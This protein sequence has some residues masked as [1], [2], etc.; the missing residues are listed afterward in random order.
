MNSKKRPRRLTRRDFIRWGSGSAL[1]AL[2][3][4]Q[5]TLKA[6]AAPTSPPRNA[7]TWPQARPGGQGAVT[8]QRLAATDGH[9][10]LPGRRN[11]D[12]KGVYVFGF[13]NASIPASI[14]ETILANKG[15]VKHPS[16]ILDFQQDNDVYLTLTNVGFEFRPDLDDSHTIHWHGFRNPNAIFDGVPEVSISVPVARDFVYYFHPRHPGTYMYHCHF[17]DTEHVQMGMDGIVFVRPTMGRN[18]AYNHPATYFDREY[19][20]LLNEVDTVPHDNLEAVQGFVWSD[21]NPNYF[22]ING[23]AYPD[24]ILRNGEVGEDPT[25][26]ESQPISSLIQINEEETG[27]LRFASL[28]YEQH[29][30][31][32]VGIRMHV[33][34]HDATPLYKANGNGGFV[35]LTYQTSTIY[36][37]A[38]EA[39]DVLFTAPAYN[40]ALPGGVDA[41]IGPYNV[42]WLRNR[43]YRTLTNNGLPGL[44]GMVTQV[45]VYQGNPLPPQTAPN[46]TYL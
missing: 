30:M 19:T 13:L 36:L 3:G 45:R 17:E 22:V 10:S 18:F 33:V 37:G 6:I 34:G 41:G 9:I 38:G 25:L 8:T 35:D 1:L 23:R 4:M 40:P 2:A 21:Y 16:P 43:N 46:Q 14:G 42:Y 28:G 24:T 29:A 32:L 11:S 15:K 7:V 20:L 44:G 31:Q 12:G 39:R 27:L 26:E 5:T